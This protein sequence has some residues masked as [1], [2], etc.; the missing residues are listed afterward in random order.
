MTNEQLSSMS[1]YYSEKYGMPKTDKDGINK[2]VSM[3]RELFEEIPSQSIKEGIAEYYRNLS[4]RDLPAYLWIAEAL[5]ATSKKDVSKRSFQ[6]CIGILRSWMKNGFGHIPNQ[7]EDELVAYFEEMTGQCVTPKARRILQNLMG[8]YGLIKVTRMMGGLKQE[9]D[10]STI[11][12]SML[13][14][15]MNE[16][17]EQTSSESTVVPIKKLG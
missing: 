10:L 9:L 7:E 4:N 2:L 16:K 12:M 15:S 6:Y 17:Y 11:Y 5:H 13:S 1:L 8:Q 14:E 3:Y